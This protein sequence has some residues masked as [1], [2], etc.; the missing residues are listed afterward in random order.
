M[1]R[2]MFTLACTLLCTLTLTAQPKGDKKFSPEQFKERMEK[3]LIKHADLTNDEAKKVLPIFMEM[4]EQQRK[5]GK[6]LAKLKKNEKDSNLSETEYAKR[7]K[8]INEL[9][10]DLAEVEE[11]YYEKMMKAIPA[12]K[13]WRIMKA[14]D[15][16]HR[17]MLSHFNQDRGKGAHPG[18]G[19]RPGMHKQKDN[20]QHHGMHKQKGNGPRPGGM[21]RHQEAD[22][23]Q[24]N[25]ASQQTACPNEGTCCNAEE[26]CKA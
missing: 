15:E 2:L 8:Q 5:L 7:V 11:K 1:K 13:V 22:P 12:S 24:G 9:K 3:A 23:Q 16:F 14:D 25:E 17:Q 20:G 4:K 21:R 10:E 26:P 18:N 6:N 19:Q